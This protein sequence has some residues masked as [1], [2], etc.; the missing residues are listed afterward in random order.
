VVLLLYCISLPRAGDASAGA[1][2]RRLGS[3]AADQGPEGGPRSAPERSPRALR[4]RVCPEVRL[5]TPSRIPA[6]RATASG[7]RAVPKHEA[8]LCEERKREYGRSDE[9]E[10]GEYE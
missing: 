2:K 1:A 6:G 9:G 7:H 10:R 8:K 4:E 3:S 5:E